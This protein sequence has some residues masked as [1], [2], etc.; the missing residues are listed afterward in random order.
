VTRV[1]WDAGALG[2]ALPGSVVRT[3]PTYDAAEPLGG[4]LEARLVRYYGPP[5]FADG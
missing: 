5:P 4:D 3:A 1:R 2:V